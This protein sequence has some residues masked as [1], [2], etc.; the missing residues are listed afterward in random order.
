MSCVMDGGPCNG[1]CSDCP[2]RT[3]DERESERIWS[4][5][6]RIEDAMRWRDWDE[7]RMLQDELEALTDDG[8]E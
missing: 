2:R 8:W 7:V 3:F 1:A 4:L 6:D 5:R